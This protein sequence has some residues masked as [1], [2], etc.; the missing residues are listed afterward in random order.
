MYNSRF[1]YKKSEFFTV[2]QITA[3]IGA[4]VVKEDDLNKKVFGISTLDSSD[5]TQIS[6]LNSARYLAKFTVSKAGFCL[7]EEKYLA[8]A[9]ATMTLLIH[10]NPYFAYAK[11]AE[12]FYAEKIPEFIAGELIHPAAKIG[13]GTKIAPNAYIGKDVEIGK[14]CLI[15][16]GA[17]VMDN[18]I[19]G[20]NCVINAGAVISF[21]VIGVNCI[22]HNGAKIGQD[23]FGFAHNVGVNHKIIQ[24][25]IV[26][27]GNDVEIGANS[28]IDRGAIENTIIGD[29]TKL[30][31]LIQ[32]GHNVIIGKGTVIAGC[33][34]V[35]GSTKI[36]N[37]VQIGGKCSINGHISIGDGAKIAGMSGVMRSVKPMEVVGGAPALPIKK[38]HKL[39]AALF[40]M[41]KSNKDDNVTDN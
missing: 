41:I 39:N 28:C 33:A 3:T 21:A 36:G 13:K 31:N 9:P 12:S 19:I 27:I 17:S 18:C 8:K 29:G 2:A 4:T 22:I 20:D 34:A 7:I 40:R 25:G 10:K 38:W 32:I 30:D 16:P 37:F 23:G 5:K 35:A 26:Q 24:L 1:F 15:G 6:F 11:I 14:N